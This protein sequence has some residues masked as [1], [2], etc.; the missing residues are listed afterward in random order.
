M[1][2]FLSKLKIESLISKT[3][4]PKGYYIAKS[5]LSVKLNIFKKEKE[6]NVF[7]FSISK[8][9]KTSLKKAEAE[10]YERFYVSYP[11]ISKLIPPDSFVNTFSWPSLKE[12]KPRQASEVFIG[13]EDRQTLDS[14]GVSFGKSFK[15]AVETSIYE[16]CERHLLGRIWY[17]GNLKLIKFKS[18][19]LLKSVITANFYRIDGKNIPCFCLV[20]LE[21]SHKKI[22]LAGSSVCKTMG[23]AEEKA[24]SEAVM[25]FYDLQKQS[26]PQY[27][28]KKAN[29]HWFSLRGKESLKRKKYFENN[30]VNLNSNITF[31]LIKNIYDLV[32]FT[33]GN[34]KNHIEIVQ[35]YN[36]KNSYVIRA[37]SRLS[38]FP[39]NYRENNEFEKIPSDPF[40]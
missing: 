29:R 14:S 22:W 5:G 36:I 18:I 10:L 23:V 40:S 38:L 25:L 35:I 12:I 2:K 31:K 34:F 3:K 24:F 9:R 19:I 28:S 8:N 13:Y 16:L 21:D 1:K 26:T 11:A 17:S 30:I 15:I 32:K 20:I 27:W 4:Y 37:L 6:F 7:G 39:I 33:F